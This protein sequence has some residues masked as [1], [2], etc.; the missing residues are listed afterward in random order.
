MIR[1]NNPE[2]LKEFG[3]TIELTEGWARSV[4][5]NLNWSKRRATTGKVEPP[6]Q[7]LAEEKFTFQK[8]IAEAIH[9]NDIPP[10]LLINI[11]QTP[12][13]MSHQEG[14]IPF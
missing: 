11:D 14:Y 4:L 7:L 1:A 6:A 9:D 5:K 8:A 12:Y 3:I 13:V 2:M 10:D